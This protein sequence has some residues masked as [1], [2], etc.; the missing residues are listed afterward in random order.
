MVVSIIQLGFEVFWPRIRARVGKAGKTQPF[1]VGYAFV[2][3][4]ESAPWRRIE[5]TIGVSAMLRA[6]DA[7]AHC[8]DAEIGRLLR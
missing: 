8:P 1:F 2:R 3:L 4:D 5:R 6:G 7:P